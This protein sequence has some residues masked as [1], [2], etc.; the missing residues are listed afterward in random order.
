MPI[1]HYRKIIYIST[2]LRHPFL[3]KYRKLL[4]PRIKLL[5]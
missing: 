2:L 4:V 3:E 1:H 5:E